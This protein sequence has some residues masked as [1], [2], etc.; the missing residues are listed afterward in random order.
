MKQKKKSEKS[1]IK[2]KKH[3][4]T[5]PDRIRIKS[6]QL[7]ALDRGSCFWFLDGYLLTWL[8]NRSKKKQHLISSQTSPERAKN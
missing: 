1:H 6:F 3:I 2:L 7:G 4:Y 5:Y 8:N